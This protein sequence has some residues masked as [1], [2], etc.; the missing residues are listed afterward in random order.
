MW[1][2][3]PAVITGGMALQSP[4]NSRG[5]RLSYA[6]PRPWRAREGNLDLRIRF[7]NP[8]VSNLEDMG[9]VLEKLMRAR[10]H[11]RPALDKT[12]EINAEILNKSEQLAGQLAMFLPSSCVEFGGSG[13]LCV[14]ESQI[15]GNAPH[16]WTAHRLAAWD[17][18]PVIQ[19]PCE[20]ECHVDLLFM[21]KI[22]L[23]REVS[24]SKKLA[25]TSSHGSRRR[26]AV[27]SPSIRQSSTRWLGQASKNATE[28]HLEAVGAAV[29][30]ED[31]TMPQRRG[32]R[33]DKD[34]I[35]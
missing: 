12:R 5:R 7:A 34:F 18:V 9:R 1:R 32:V 22:V 11:E 8:V 4:S 6:L 21:E 14:L 31:K 10:R 3:N 29:R 33:V 23:V 35:S 25:P 20:L 27:P 2:I 19:V 30:T 16:S 15:A 17:G 24:F 26:A 28:C 13:V